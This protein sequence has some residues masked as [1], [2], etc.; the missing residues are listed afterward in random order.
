MTS[1]NAYNFSLLHTQTD[2]WVRLQI[3]QALERS[4]LTMMEWLLLQAVNKQQATGLTITAA[5]DLLGVS[6]P[7]ITA[8]THRL[9][10]RELLTLS[11]STEDRRSRYLQI[12]DA[13]KSLSKAAT[14]SVKDLLAQSISQSSQLETYLKQLGDILDKK[15]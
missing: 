15:K 6:L 7:Q 3:A 14:I 13:G 12:T 2:R 11:V 10:E 8:L 4:S 1:I 9:Q 5:A